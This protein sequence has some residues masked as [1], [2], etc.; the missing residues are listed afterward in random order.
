M[1]KGTHLFS[2][3]NGKF[4]APPLS[5]AAW[6]QSASQQRRPLVVLVHAVEVLHRH[7]RRAATKQQEVK[8]NRRVARQPRDAVEVAVVAGEV[9]KAIR[10]HD[11]HEQGVVAEQAMLLAQPGGEGN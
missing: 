2:Q 6:K 5:E 4:D 7:A 3:A 11:G 1:E 9:G 10:L 8:S